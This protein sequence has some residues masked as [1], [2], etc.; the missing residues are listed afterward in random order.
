MRTQ[1]CSDPGQGTSVKA[2][3]HLAGLDESKEAGVTRSEGGRSWRPLEIRAW[4]LDFNPSVWGAM[5]GVWAVVERFTLASVWRVGW[6][7]RAASGK[8]A[9]SPLQE[10][11]GEMLLPQTEWRSF[12]R[13][14][15]LNVKVELAEFVGGVSALII[16]LFVLVIIF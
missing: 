9:S 11:R 7:P 8:P 13:G 15:E 4:W 2:P 3:V 14:R 16:F 12:D 6:G 5:G 1:W 10:C